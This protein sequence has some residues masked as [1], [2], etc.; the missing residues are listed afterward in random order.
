[1]NGLLW[2]SLGWIAASFFIACLGAFV[3]WKSDTQVKDEI[4]RD[5]K[6]FIRK[7]HR[8]PDGRFE[9]RKAVAKR[10]LERDLKTEAANNK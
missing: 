3:F 1:M 6:E 7:P 2:F 4:D 9:S 10:C 8:G 5:W